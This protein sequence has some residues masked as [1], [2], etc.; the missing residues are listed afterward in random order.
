[1][2]EL[3]LSETKAVSGAAINLPSQT[4]GPG[5][6]PIEQFG[7]ISEGLDWVGDIL[8]GFIGGQA[9]DMFTTTPTAAG[10]VMDANDIDGVG[11]NSYGQTYYTDTDTNTVYWDNDGDGTIDEAVTVGP[12]ATT[13]TNSLGVQIVWSTMGN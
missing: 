2:R 13:Y 8:G 6:I 9:S 1:M 7:L 5:G 12:E 3:K 11:V 10:L 4:P